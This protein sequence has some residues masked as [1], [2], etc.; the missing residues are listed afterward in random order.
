M[1]SVMRYGFRKLCRVWAV[2]ATALLLTVSSITSAQ[3]PTPTMGLEAFEEKEILALDPER[4]TDYEVK[5]VLSQAP[6]PHIILFKGTRFADMESFG[7]FLA[8][9]GYP[10]TKLRNPQRRGY[11]YELSWNFTGCA[12]LDC[13]DMVGALAWYYET[14]GIVPMLIGHSGGGVNVS[15]ILYGLANA[16]RSIRAEAGD[17][18]RIFV[19]NPV[20]GKRDYR[21]MV[22]DP[23]TGAS[24]HVSDLRVPYAVMFATGTLMRWW[25]GFPGC[26]EDIPKLAYIPESVEDFTGFQIENDGFTSG[27]GEFSSRLPGNPFPV[28]LNFMLPSTVDHINAFKMD[29][30]ADNAKTRAWINAYRPEVYEPIPQDTGLDVSNILHAAHMWYSIKKH[31]C[32]EAQR[33]ILAKQTVAGKPRH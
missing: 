21:D 33:L 5:H 19:W 15:R 10:A 14:D 17:K 6:T 4:I 8:Q 13:D 30:L 9:M 29:G 28:V 25:P 11:S 18:R 20:T 16:N 3:A 26:R 22:R 7:G 1:Q 32:V 24:R 31:W 2:S 23:V 12:C 27:F